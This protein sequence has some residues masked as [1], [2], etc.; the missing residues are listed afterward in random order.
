MDYSSI[1]ASRS[2]SE[3]E[4]TAGKSTRLRDCYRVLGKRKPGLD[5]VAAVGMEGEKK[6][7]GL[8]GEEIQ[9]WLGVM[10][11]QEKRKERKTPIVQ[12]WKETLN[13][14]LYHMIRAV[15]VYYK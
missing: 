14:K 5:G 10:G 13:F 9:G 11:E 2:R 3:T 6:P 4:R 15:C 8:R 1:C 7:E 12:I